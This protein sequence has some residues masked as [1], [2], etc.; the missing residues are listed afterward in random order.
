[1]TVTAANA[2]IPAGL[3][4]RAY[5]SA[6]IAGAN[7]HA[8]GVLF[9]APDGDVL[10][11]RR[12][13]GE[14][15]FPGYWSLPGGNADDGETPEQ[16]AVREPKEEM[17]IDVDPA[18][19]RDMEKVVTPKGKCF[20]TFAVQAAEKFVPKLNSEHSGYAWA[21]LDMLPRPMH[22]ALD[23]MLKKRLGM[24]Q[25]MSVS[26][27]SALRAGLS[28][29]LREGERAEIDRRSAF[30][31]KKVPVLAGDELDAAIR[32]TMARERGVPGAAK[33]T[34]TLA[35][36]R[37]SVRWKRRDGQLV[38]ERSHITKA[39]VCPY[40]TE[41]IPGWDAE[42]GTHALGLEP[43]K[44]YQLLRD[45]DELRKA[46]PTLNGVQL[47][48]VHKPT[49]A[50]DHQPY[51]TV[52]SVGSNAEAVE[53]DGDLYLDNA[54]YVNAASAIDGIE[55][56]RKRELSAGY[57]YVPD[58]TPGIF[59]GTRYDGVMRDIVFNHVALVEDGRAGPDVVV[60]DSRENLMAGK[61]TR[62][63]AMVLAATAAQLSPLLAMDQ[64]ITLSPDLVNT[65]AGLTSKNFG[66]SK[67]KL[68]SGVRLAVDGKLR[69]GVALDNSMAG[70]K[71]AVDAFEELAGGKA[72]EPSEATMMDTVEPVA[73]V[74]GTGA[75]KAFD[76]EGVANFL[77]GKG[78]GEDDIKAACDMF[79][80]NGL[81]G[82]E[83]ESDEDK[84]KKAKAEE[85]DKA[86]KAKESKQAMDEQ[87]KAT[88]GT[89][90]ETAVKA[91]RANQSGIRAAL[92]EVTPWVG[93]IPPTMAFDDAAGVYRHALGMLNVSGADKLHSEALLPVLKAQPKPG[94]PQRQDQSTTI[95]AMDASAV[96][97]AAKL[98]PGISGISTDLV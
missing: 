9:V 68:L 79:P 73:A 69:A 47:L 15:N 57:H 95:I 31:E 86:K 13:A 84:A 25:D 78:L 66:T 72:D 49:S 6:A 48:Q 77:R 96:D 76:A 65:F 21:S 91:E 44:V 93:Q 98:A 8:A 10:M 59:R 26:D 4:D 53:E 33:R 54:L 51:D 71:A 85:E 81:A 7:G 75:T 11:L 83:D 14:E 30:D 55:A 16:A 56:K 5:D 61:A 74:G 45:P 2:A 70:L 90:V 39:N 67:E 3:R 88:V 41:E 42:T 20:H 36:D 35:L 80:Q 64:K 18:S 87:I 23:D 29:W 50:E 1:M 19:L 12:A 52:G 60:G 92:A 40:R 38:V 97:L 63:G 28:Q 22:P 27:W 46:A 34:L 24:G 62:L 37:D 89:A 32:A 58:M 17:G 94:A 43:G 82:D